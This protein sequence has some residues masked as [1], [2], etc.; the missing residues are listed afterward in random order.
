VD[1]GDRVGSIAPLADDEQARFGRQQPAQAMSR[2]RIVISNDETDGFRLMSH[3]LL[4]GARKEPMGR[5]SCSTL[6]R[7]LIEPLT[8]ELSYL[9]IQPLMSALVSWQ[10][11]TL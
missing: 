8:G 3:A 10:G 1:E 4:G 2:N 6:E 5:E 11:A 7:H 9:Q